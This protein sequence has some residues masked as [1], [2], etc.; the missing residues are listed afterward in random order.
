MILELADH[1]VELLADGADPYAPAADDLL[2]VGPTNAPAAGLEPRAQP[3]APQSPT[4]RTP[5]GRGTER[6]SHAWRIGPG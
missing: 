3:G 2:R 6:R 1:P 4:M 5:M